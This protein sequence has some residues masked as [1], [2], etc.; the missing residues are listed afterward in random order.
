MLS[1]AHRLL[2]KIN[3][4]DRVFIAS[5]SY[6]AARDFSHF[7]AGQVYFRSY[8]RTGEQKSQAEQALKWYWAP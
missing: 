2:T 5:P 3:T 7:G 8:L 4:I 1:R 6:K